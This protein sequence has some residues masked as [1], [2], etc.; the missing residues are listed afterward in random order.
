MQAND[1]HEQQVSFMHM[2]D[3]LTELNSSAQ[4]ICERFH[5]IG[6]QFAEATTLMES[7][8][9][10]MSTTSDGLDDSMSV[11]RVNQQSRSPRENIVFTDVPN[12]Y[13]RDNL[14][15]EHGGHYAR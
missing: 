3:M 15:W 11:L 5:D 7:I 4:T 1:L 9:R 8:L 6:T 12:A 10:K 2:R 13:T 14:H